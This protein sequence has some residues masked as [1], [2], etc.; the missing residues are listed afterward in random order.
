LSCIVPMKNKKNDEILGFVFH[1][2]MD[3]DKKKL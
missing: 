1:E 2:A 3:G